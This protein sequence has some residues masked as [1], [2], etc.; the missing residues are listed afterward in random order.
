MNTLTRV[1]QRRQSAT[2]SALRNLSLPLGILARIEQLDAHQ[3]SQ[4][5]LLRR[6]SITA[7]FRN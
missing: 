3:L 6:P 5:A 4:P 1:R 2:S 7:S